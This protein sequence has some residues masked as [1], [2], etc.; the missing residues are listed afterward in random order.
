M[1]MSPGIRK[2]AL[3]THVTCS[4]GWLGAVATFLA[5]AIVGLTSQEDVV[6]R[7]AYVAMDQTTSLV[8]VPLSLASTVT[9]L[10]QSLGTTWGLFRHYWV[11]A[12]LVITVPSTIILLTHTRAIR[13]M[14]L[15][16]ADIP[17]LS[18]DLR[19]LRVQL[20]IT[21]GAAVL[22]LLV[23]TAL[24]VYKPRGLTPYGWRKQ[25]EQ[26][27]VSPDLDAAM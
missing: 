23:T 3:T 15:A 9:G 8:I 22:A 6:V 1:I 24:S 20:A 21:A 25:R 2:L 27:L 11:L 17:L 14:A 5:L 10:L 12:K 26:R 4:I 19:E 13:Y 7:S 16:A 18:G